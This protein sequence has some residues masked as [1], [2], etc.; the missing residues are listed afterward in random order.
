MGQ[1]SEAQKAS[2]VQFYLSVFLEDDEDYSDDEDVTW[3]VRRAAAKAIEAM[4]SSHRDS[5]LTLSSKIGPTLINRFKEREETVRTEIFSAYIALL[6]QI[7][8]IV[9][10]IQKAVVKVSD[11]NAIETD[12]LMVIGGTH[13]STNYLSKDQL[14]IVQ[15]LADQKI[16][17]LKSIARS[18]KRHPKT[19]PKCIEL[20]TALIRTYPSGLEDSLDELIPGVSHV[21]TDKNASAQGKMTVLSFVSKALYLNDASKF[22]KLLGPLTTVITHSI[23]DQFYKVSAEGLS[24]SCRYIEVLKEL[25]GGQEARKILEVVEK[26]FMAN[27]TDQEVREKSIAAISQLLAAFKED[28]KKEVS[29]DFLKLLSGFRRPESF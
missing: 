11:E 9:P 26:K 24:V 18:M 19:G 20:L 6:N 14:N 10:D 4:I 7:S 2:E 21:L 1:A 15:S 5:L 16:S 25:K 12:D 8:I 27:D 28:F 23:S 22:V 17:L 3:K 13:Y 29:F